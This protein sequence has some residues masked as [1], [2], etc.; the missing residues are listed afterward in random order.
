MAP[1]TVTGPESRT[2]RPPLAL[3]GWGTPTAMRALMRMSS[4]RGSALKMTAFSLQKS[5]G[6]SARCRF[7]TCGDRILVAWPGSAVNMQISCDSFFQAFLARAY[8]GQLP[9]EGLFEVL[10]K[11]V[12]VSHNGAS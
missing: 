3:L 7:A 4:V 2:G 11:F 5:I 6:E 9:K 10:R 1:M 12:P 8:G